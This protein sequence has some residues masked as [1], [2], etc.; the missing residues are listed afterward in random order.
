MTT[1]YY[2]LDAPRQGPTKWYPSRRSPV[3]LIVLH[4][5]AGL[6]DHSTD[7]QSAEATARYAAA[8]DRAVSWHAG[9]DTDSVVRLLPPNY[10]AFHCAGYN[11]SS[12][13]L[14]ISKR[15]VQWT[16][17][18]PEW[19]RHTL[20][21]AAA[22]VRPWMV[23]FAIPPVL[24]TRQQ[25]DAGQSG[26]CYHSRLDPARR[27][28]PG[29]DFPWLSFAARLT[30]PQEDDEMAFTDKDSANLEAAK[31]YLVDQQRQNARIIELLEQ[32]AAKPC[33][34]PHPGPVFSPIRRGTIATGSARGSV[35]KTPPRAGRHLQRRCRQ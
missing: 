24:L 13:G 20:D 25:V 22:A 8:T 29:P 18:D 12:L 33:N 30:S 6:E 5:T 19:V 15:T 28:D 35:D 23:E 2:L 4:I 10:T 21:N 7:D 27:G 3:R 26:F 11:S 1:G 14:E 31:N 9:A 34:I 16:G 17:M 32:L